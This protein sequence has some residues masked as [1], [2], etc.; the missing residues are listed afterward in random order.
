MEENKLSNKDKLDKLI[1]EGKVICTNW[2]RGCFNETVGYKKCLNCREKDRV[3]DK[4]NR[5]KKKNT[6]IEYNKLNTETKQCT[7]CNVVVYNKTFN[8]NTNKCI[9]CYNKSLDSNKVRNPRDKVKNKIY[10]IKSGAKK[11]DINME[12]S[13][14]EISKIIQLNCHYCG[15]N[16]TD[17]VC[18]IDRIDSMKGYIKSNCVPCCEQCNLMKNSRTQDD[19]I[20]ICEHIV[21]KKK[22]Y[23]GNTDH[24]LFITPKTRTY[25]NYR[26]DAEK[27]NKPFILSK[28]EY[29]VLINKKCKYCHTKPAGGIDRI[30]SCDGYN[31][32]NCVA[33]CTTCN[34]M[35]LNYSKDDFINKCM[36]ITQY[37]NGTKKIEDDI[38]KFFNKYSDNKEGIKRTNPSFLHSKDFY[39][40]RKWYGDI[41]DLEKVHIELEFVETIEQRDIWNYYRWTV[42]SLKTYK[43][44]NF[45]GRIICILVKDKHTN[46]YIG[47]MS[48]SSDILH[49]ME[50]DNFIGW[51]QDEK[52]KN[53]KINHIMNLS[54]CVSIQPFGFNFNGGKLLAKLAFSQEVIEKFKTK[55]NQ[56][57]LGIVTTGLYGKSIQYDRLKE[58]KYIGNTKGNSIFWIPPEITSICRKYLNSVHSINTSSYKKMDVITRTIQLLGLN[59]EDI[60]S[61]NPKGIYFGFTRPD[62]KQYLCGAVNKLNNYKFNTAQELFKDWYNRWAIQRYMH[63]VYTDK[64]INT[65]YKKSTE[66]ANRYYNIIK[67]ELTETEYK[68]YIKD[69]NRK[70][71][72]KMKQNIQTNDV[73]APKSEAPKSEAPKSEA[74]KSEAPKSEAPKSEA[75]K[76][77]APKSE[78]LKSEASKDLDLPNNISIFKDKSCNHNFEFNKSVDKVR[79]NLKY[80]LKSN[81]IQ[82]E[83]NKFLEN[84]N[85]KYPELKIP[86]YTI[87]HIPEKYNNIIKEPEQIQNDTKPD[88]P[89]NFSICNVNGTDYI[90]FCKMIDNKKHQYKTRINSYDLQSELNRFVDYLN[91]TYKFTTVLTHDVVT[92]NGWRTTNNIICHDD[93]PEKLA[94]RERANNY[95][96]KKREELG[97][98]KY[99]EMLRV[100]ASTYRDK[101]DIYV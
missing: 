73:I 64:I 39:E 4:N 57:L 15:D 22:L 65:T 46:K 30:D 70:Y 10:D 90:Q 61:S 47:I 78:A 84:V 1:Q 44:D 41:Y 56:D 86:N 68:N 81:D 33:C 28:E 2:I 31:N 5:D 40:Y 93:T 87:Q 36:K 66:R 12:L 75:P 92:T 95:N 23:D 16:D 62:S 60:I 83:L 54:T 45:M 32:E 3:N 35:K 18:G 42:S 89:N 91:E 6:A 58:I 27:R 11:R 43:P 9:E 98:E 14:D 25:S 76:S 82:S 53:K 85:T 21:T 19:F 101:K 71:N 74:P 52:I 37:I 51:S 97:E 79:K 100:R 94:S 59:K 49:M 72:N 88:M 50:R 17:M 38:I 24:S 55:F 26:Y 99:K 8:E 67:N 80:K 7:V 96:M 29:T 34:T 63:L 77:E 13:D 48:L 69:K 20:K